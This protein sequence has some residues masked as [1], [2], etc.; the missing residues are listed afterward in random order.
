MCTMPSATTRMDF[1]ILK[2]E[3]EDTPPPANKT[4]PEAELE[5]KRHIESFPTL[6]SHYARKDSQ[7]KY[8]PGD[9]NVAKMYQLYVDQVKAK[10]KDPVSIS[11]YRHIF[12]NDFN[13]AFHM[14]KKD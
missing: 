14:P 12:N 13:L 1:S 11:V 10:G 7:R 9:L 3:E 5:V 6:E 4:P 8:L 2:K